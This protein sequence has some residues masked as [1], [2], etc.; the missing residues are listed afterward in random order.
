MYAPSQWETTLHC[1]IVSHRLGAYTKWSLVVSLF[2]F[3]YFMYDTPVKNIFVAFYNCAV[4]VHVQQFR[5][6]ISTNSLVLYRRLSCFD[7][8]VFIAFIYTYWLYICIDILYTL[9]RL[10][11]N[12]WIYIPSALTCQD[13]KRWRFRNYWR[14]TIPPA[15]DLSPRKPRSHRDSWWAGY[16][17]ARLPSD[18]SSHSDTWR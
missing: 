16:P 7:T 4:H 13:C 8:E 15:S 5:Y 12:P 14:P 17:S 18:L 1:S 3:R 11:M 2:W 10:Q 6:I 9:A